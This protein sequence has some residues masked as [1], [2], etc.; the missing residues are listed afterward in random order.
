MSKWTTARM[1]SLQGKVSIVTGANSG[2]GWVT[3]RELARKGA[4]V[5]LACRDEK[6]GTEAVS[7][8]RQAV[9]D[10]SVSLELVDMANLASIRAFVERLDLPTIDLL[11]NNAGV[12]AIPRR[13]TA[14]GFEMQLGTNHLGHFALTGLLLPKLMRSPD[15]RVVT[16]SSNAH[17]FGRMHMDD[18]MGERSYGA[19]SAYNQSKLANLLF[20]AE[21]QRRADHKQMR[22]RS[23]ACHP[24]YASTNLVAVGP[25]MK[26]A[27]FVE[28]VMVGFTRIFGQTAE[29]GAL[30]SLYAATAE[31]VR[32]NDYIGPGSFF[33]TRGYPKQVSRS[34]RARD[35]AMAERLWERSVELTGVE[36][37]AL[38]GD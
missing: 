27:G 7:A 28:R 24:G 10:A 19:W 2:I 37:E 31:D 22:L 9:A 18:L 34:A 25:R 6:R 30:P 8:L 14:D 21:L 17:W 20:V 4:H 3:A 35:R 11:V 32:G 36:W 13:T 1:P 38:G 12:M 5:V 16:V 33:G 15:A 26:G 29:M 23:V